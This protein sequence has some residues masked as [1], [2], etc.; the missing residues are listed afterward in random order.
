MAGDSRS[1]AVEA[2]ERMG[3][4]VLRLQQD[5]GEAAGVFRLE[6]NGV[7][8]AR[9]ETWAGR[10]DVALLLHTSGTTRGPSWCR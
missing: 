5:P 4:P 10:D 8:A 3:V 6:G 9:D 7:A 1:A 2:A